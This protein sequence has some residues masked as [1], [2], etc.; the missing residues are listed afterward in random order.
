MPMYGAV[1]VPCNE[2][3][4]GHTKCQGQENRDLKI[5]DAAI[6]GIQNANL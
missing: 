4:L 3:I 2:V 1:N 6:K 5:Q